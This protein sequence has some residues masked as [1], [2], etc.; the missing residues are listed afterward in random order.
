MCNLQVG[1]T[2]QS[3]N[4]YEKAT[5]HYDREGLLFPDTVDFIIGD[6]VFEFA[7]FPPISWHVNHCYFE[8]QKPP[9]QYHPYLICTFFC[10]L[11]VY[12][13]DS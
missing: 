4:R 9:N 5:G 3:M 6:V 13:L 1:S 11:E 10:L 2:V 8:V 12:V 7:F